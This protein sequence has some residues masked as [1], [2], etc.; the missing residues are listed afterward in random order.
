MCEIETA[1]RTTLVNRPSPGMNRC[2]T[3]DLLLAT[4]RRGMAEAILGFVVFWLVH[5]ELH[6][7]NIATQR[8]A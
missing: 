4:E 6:V 5:D 1:S 2:T 7:L 3:I 8:W